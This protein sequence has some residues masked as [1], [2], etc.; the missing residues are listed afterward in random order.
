MTLFI[1]IFPAHISFIFQQW[2][3]IINSFAF[4][5]YEKMRVKKYNVIIWST[6]NMVSGAKK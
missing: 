6:N 2:I 5:F 1:K 4:L 3:F